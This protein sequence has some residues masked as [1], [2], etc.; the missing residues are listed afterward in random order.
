MN[1]TFVGYNGPDTR[2]PLFRA[3]F[4]RNKMVHLE[5]IRSGD[6]ALQ[7]WAAATG[8]KDLPGEFV[9]STNPALA[10]VLPSG[11]MPYYGYGAGIVKLAV[12]DN[13]E[14]GGSNRSSNGEFLMFLPEATVTAAG[15]TL[16]DSGRFIASP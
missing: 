16:I 7:T 4:V 2:S 10:A 13:W 8:D 5:S 15:R 12:G 9:I 1:G 6:A 14:S 3:T 11:Y